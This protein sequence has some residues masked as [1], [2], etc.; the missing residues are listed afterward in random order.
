M[1]SRNGQPLPAD[2]VPDN[3]L[4]FHTFLLQKDDGLLQTFLGALKFQCHFPDLLVDARPT[5]IRNHVVF[6]RHHVDHGLLDEMLRKNQRDLLPCHQTSFVTVL[7]SHTIAS[8]VAGATM[9]GESPHTAHDGSRRTAT[10]RA[11]DAS[12][13][14]TKSRSCSGVPNPANSFSASCAMRLPMRPATAPSTPASWQFGI[15]PGAGGSGK[16]P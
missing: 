5:N 9:L 13:S 7:P 3:G 6:L 16:T 15:S 11:V 12:P 8:T 2:N 1:G 4:N 10:S 14:N